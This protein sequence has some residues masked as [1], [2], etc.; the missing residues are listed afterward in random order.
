MAACRTRTLPTTHVLSCSVLGGCAI[1]D[2]MRGGDQWAMV[3]GPTAI[4]ERTLSNMFSGT[5]LFDTTSTLNH[6]HNLRTPT[7]TGK[8]NIS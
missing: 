5:A 2:R 1:K 6:Q 7:L 3:T 8:M 4:L